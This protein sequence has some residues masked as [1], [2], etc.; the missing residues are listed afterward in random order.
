MATDAV[1]DQ[2]SLDGALGLISSPGALLKDC[3]CVWMCIGQSHP[4][5]MSNIKMLVYKVTQATL[6][7]TND[8]HC[9]LKPAGHSPS[10]KEAVGREDV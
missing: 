1:S 2:S 10:W 3:L 7:V 6:V 8:A 5:T 4:N 9:H